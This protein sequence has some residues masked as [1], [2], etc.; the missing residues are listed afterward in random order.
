MLGGAVL[1]LVL[2][3]MAALAIWRADSDRDVRRSLEQRSGVVAALNDARAQFY[4]GAMFMAITIFAE[5]KATFIDMYREA[6]VQGDE[7]TEEARDGLIALGDA[8]G[9]ARVAGFVSGGDDQDAAVNAFSEY[10]L[11]APSE[12]VAQV[13]EAYLAK[14]WPEAESLVAELGELANEQQAKLA[15]ERA[16]A[17]R[18]GDTTLGLLMAFG[19]FALVASGGT[20]VALTRSV[21][22]P[23]G[24]LRES[25][26][27]ITSG[28]MEAKAA[29]SGPQE[30]ASLARDFN[31]MVSAR[32]RAEG[33]LRKARDELEMRVRERTAALVAANEELDRLARTDAVT[34][35]ANHRY[36]N[37]S[38]E[39]AMGRARSLGEALSVV[40]VDVDDFKLFNDT[41]G[42]ALGDEVLRLVAR[43]LREMS[44]ESGM[45]SRYG[46]DEF[47]VVLPGADKAAASA[48]ADRLA[49]AVGEKEFEVEGGSKVPVGLSLGVASYPADS[50]SKDHLLAL[51]D[52]AMY[53]AKRL[54]GTGRGAP[55]VVAVGGALFESAFGAL[56]SLVQAVQYRDRYT[57]THSDLVAEYAAKLGLRAGLSEETGRALR[58]A[59]ALHDIGKIIVPDEILKK[60]GP[61]SAAEFEVIK[62]HPSVGETL[63]QE[64]PFLEDVIQAVGCH[65]EH[66]DGSGYPRGLRG[67][68]IPLAGRVMAIADAY[69]AMCLDRP[70]RKALSAE[71]TILELRTGAGS[72]F[73][74][75][76]VGIFIEM[77]DAESQAKVA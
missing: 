72:S 75:R 39:E 21:V 35:L 59:G 69:S 64:T 71:E 58:I 32:R 10:L 68:E 31:E 28:D 34:G 61:L 41:Y 26:R 60:P 54:G 43:V 49:G 70:Y 5:D 2:I 67:E 73:D 14:Q 1:L 18:A 74:P 53:E 16:A 7:S 29:V 20:L 23:L 9:L 38:L 65:H 30:V 4:L 8:E 22:S 63:I 48:F 13:A 25:V 44:G 66:Y 77:L 33:E 76:L 42:H 47:L 46:G 11:S 15:A 19:L 55:H 50:E 57:K 45:P 52:A 17:D 24:S 40:I 56:E 6:K 27:A 36:G 12:T 51:A 62:R 37:A 3:G